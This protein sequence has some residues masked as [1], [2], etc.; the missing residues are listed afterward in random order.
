MNLNKWNSL[1]SDV[2]K[3]FEELGG[4]WFAGFCGKANDAVNIEGKKL[5]Q[6]T[7]GKTTITLSRAELE[8]FKTA[9]G[10]LVGEWI[11]DL[12]A[13]G[14]PGKAVVKETRKLFEK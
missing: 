1:S 14:L 4:D 6:S 2:Q 5:F 13:K 10:P 12:E 3:V 8:K 7:S 9:A 11:S